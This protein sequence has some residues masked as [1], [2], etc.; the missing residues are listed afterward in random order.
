MFSSKKG[1]VDDKTKLLNQ[2]QSFSASSVSSDDKLAKVQSQ[3][4]ELKNTMN[5]TIDKAIGRGVALD[6]LDDK[7]NNLQQ[8]SLIFKDR[9]TKLK[10]K[11]CQKKWGI[12]VCIAI[13]IACV[14]AILAAIIKARS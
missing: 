12:I 2:N 4:G 9:T 13:T 7:S 10:R 3:V 6:I 11:Q 1:I 5:D 14:I 8:Q